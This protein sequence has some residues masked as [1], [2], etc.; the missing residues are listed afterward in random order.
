M[1]EKSTLCKN[2]LSNRQTEI[3]TLI[4][5][6]F[7]RTQIG[8]QLSI[9]VVTIKDHIQYTKDKFEKLNLIP[10]E[11]GITALPGSSIKGISIFLAEVAANHGWIPPISLNKINFFRRY[12]QL[13]EVNIN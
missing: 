9:S 5:Q 10:I 6:G 12:H 1:I 2:Q 7:N 8:D 13:D 3:L 4:S 11:T